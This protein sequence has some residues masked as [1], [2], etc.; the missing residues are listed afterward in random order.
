MN[1]KG[2]DFIT[3]RGLSKSDW[4]GLFK[5]TDEMLSS[6]KN[7]D[8]S[9]ILKGKTAVLVF[10]SPSLRTYSFFMSAIRRLGG[11]TISYG[12]LVSSE[13]FRDETLFHAMRILSAVGDV[14]ILRHPK[15]GSAALAAEAASVPVINAGDGGNQ[16]PATAL[17]YAFELWKKNR[18]NGN[19]AF[20]GN[21]KE[22]RNVHSLLYLLSNYGATVDLVSTEDQKIPAFMLNELRDSITVRETNSFNPQGKTVVYATRMQSIV[23]A[24][25][26]LALPTDVLL[27]RK[28]RSDEEITDYALNSIAARMAIFKEILTG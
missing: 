12:H 27:L 22:S 10:F 23:P 6:L 2:K 15:D 16:H 1:L 14:I 5:T 8:H 28:R 20:V 21:L 4:E 24:E 13:I 18:L 25:Q 26:L 3:T 17:A 19:F 7:D 9:T 11:T